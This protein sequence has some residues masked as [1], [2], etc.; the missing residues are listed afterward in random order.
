ME[1]MLTSEQTL[2]TQ[3]D[4]LSNRLDEEIGNS[5]K[6]KED[7][8]ET[9]TGPAK[10]IIVSQRIVSPGEGNAPSEFSDVFPFLPKSAE[11]RQNEG[12]DPFPFMGGYE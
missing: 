7:A 9:F 3:I 10:D 5:V 8:S 12:V 4:E 11:E 1:N 6:L 2:R